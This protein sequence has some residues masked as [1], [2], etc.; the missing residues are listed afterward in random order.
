M[1][2]LGCEVDVQQNELARVCLPKH[3]IDPA[4]HVLNSQ[5]LLNHWVFR[6]NRRTAENGVMVE[7][8]RWVDTRL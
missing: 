6:L 8:N 1:K 7:V 3:V 2:H 5:P 4:F